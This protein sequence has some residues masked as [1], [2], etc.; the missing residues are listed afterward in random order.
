M[1]TTINLLDV[2]AI[3]MKAG[4]QIMDVYHSD[5]AV[6]NKE[7]KSP[8]TLADKKS[9][10]VI[11]SEL[12]RLFPKMPVL[13]EEGKHLPYEERKNWEYLWVVDPLD[14]TKEFVKR[15]GEFTV[16]IA[17]VHK[18]Y[19]VLGVIY[20]PIL[21]TIYFAKEGAGSFK[22][23]G[24]EAVNLRNEAELIS[25]SE[26]LSSRELNQEMA[27]VASRSHMSPE[28]EAYINKIQGKYGKVTITS[29][30]SSL[31]LCLVAEGKADVYPRFAPTMEWDTAA[32][33]AIVEQ[34]GGKVVQTESKERLSY[35]KENLLNPWFIVKKGS[36]MDE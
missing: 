34:A 22:I 25:H 30:G 33:Q 9:H 28:T 29:A 18:G 15:N 2:I 5:F 19:P 4:E 3:S 36:L 8:L 21:D 11:A 32:G 24:V 14:G 13:S 20:A 27:V 6:E 23:K 10:E 7:D 17:L 1:L 16:N 31:K 26:K 35:N 12:K